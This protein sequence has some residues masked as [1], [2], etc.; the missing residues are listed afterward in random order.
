[1]KWLSYPTS[2]SFINKKIGYF[3]KILMA[4]PQRGDGPFGDVD[5][6]IED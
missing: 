1:M 2:L 3:E 4:P 5:G 6:A